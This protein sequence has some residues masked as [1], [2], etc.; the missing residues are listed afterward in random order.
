M[1]KQ[2]LEVGL[3]YTSQV[4]VTQDKLASHLGSGTLDVFAT[5]AMIALMENAAMHAVM[6]AIEEGNDTVGIEINASHLAATKP[7]KKVKATATLVDIQKRI[8]IFEIVAED[9][10]KI[11]GKAT[12]KRAIINVEKFMG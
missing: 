12:H 2:V 4:E 3:T 7:G 11:I 1:M 10:D 8:L 5:P 9:E 6:P